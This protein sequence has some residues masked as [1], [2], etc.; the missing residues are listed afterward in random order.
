M[1][2]DSS[3]RFSSPY[4]RTPRT[5]LLSNGNYSLMLTSAGSG[6]SRWRDLA[7]TRW[8]EDPTCDPWGSYIFLRDVFNGHVWSAG[9]Q[10]IG[11]ESEFYEATF[12][13]DR[14]EI[15]RKDGPIRT[16]MEIFVSS[17]D[18]AEVR[19]LSLTNEGSGVREIELTSYAEVVLSPPAADSAHPAFS[20]MFVQTEYV[21]ERGA[22]L[23]TRRP[24]EPGQAQPWMA[25]FISLDAEAVG[26]LQFETDRARFLGRGHD[27]RNAVSVIDARPL[28]NTVG[29]VLDPVLALRRRVRIDPGETVHAAFWTGISASRAQ[30]LSLVDKLGSEA[31]FQRAKTLSSAKTEVQLRDSKLSIED[32]QLFQ[33]IA[34]RVLY[35]DSSQ[36]AA[37]ELLDRNQLGQ[38]DL[39][40]YGVSGDLPIVLCRIEEPAGADVLKQLLRA[41]AYWHSKCLAVDL[42]IMNAAAPASAK[43]VQAAVDAVVQDG[44]K[45]REESHAQGKVVALRA[46]AMPAEHCD[47][48]QTAARVLFTGRAAFGEQCGRPDT[49]AGATRLRR[50]NSGEELRTHAPHLVPALE[51]FNGLGGFDAGAREYVVV[52]DDGQWTPAPW[53]N[54]IANLQFGFL[55]SADG[56]GSTWSL[57]AQQNQITP[58]SN[59]PVSDTPAEAIYVRDEDSGDLW[60]VTPLPIR[61]RSS[62]YVV[63]HGF[64]YSRTEHTSHGIALTLTQFVPLEDSIKIS[65]LKIVNASDGPRQ[66]SVTH[67]VDWMLG[68]QNNRAAP[69]IITAIDPKTGALLARNPWTADFKSRVAFL[70]MTGRQQSC[71]ADRTEFIGRHGSLAEPAALL[72]PQNLSN[73]VGGGLDPCGAMQ[74]KISLSAGETVELT[75][76]LGEE[77]SAGAALSLIAR[78]RNENFDALFKGVTD[79]WD[80]TLGV[81]QV[82]TPDRSMDILINGWLLYQTLSCRVWGRTAFYQSSGAYGYR[83]QLQD[84][85]AL[86]VSSPAIAR[87]HILRA[88]AQQYAAGDVQHWWLPTSG[89]G[90][91]TRVSDDRVWLAFVVAHYLEVTGDLGV[92]DE[93]VPFLSGGPLPPGTNEHFSAPPQ[94][95]AAPLFEHCVRALDSSLSL[96]SHGLPLFGT[97]D[98]NDGMNRVGIAG[99]G[100]SVWLA[101]FLHAALMRFAPI[102]AVRGA[103]GNADVWRKHAFALAQAIERE[104]WDGDWYRRGYYDDGT[105]LG[106]ISSDECRIDSVAQSWAVISGAAERGRALRAMSAVNTQL[107]SRSDGLVKLFTPPFDHSA[108]DPGYIKAYPPGLRENGGQYTHAAMWTTLAFALLGDGDRAG[109]LFSLLNPI[110]HSSTRASIHRYKVEPYVVCADVYSAAPH[111]GRGGWTWYTG[112]AGWMYR[113]AAEGIL[114]IK[115]RGGTLVVDPCIPRAWAGFEFTYKHGSSRYRITVKNPR[116]VNRGVAQATLDGKDLSGA[117]CEIKLTDDGRYHYGEITLG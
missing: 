108:K 24:R 31:A 77:G 88:A 73:R 71:T 112:S 98:W 86:C 35:S 3:R 36:R 52:L 103:A 9:Y 40:K 83:D 105:V 10:P 8:R 111:V 109:E 14:A 113:T 33:E 72:G 84:V 48:L 61:E 57:N 107:V 23:A 116:G 37:P 11:R 63:R 69:F 115:L 85:M 96:G 17:E 99:R 104:A 20:K 110:N 66:L 81:I 12:F 93:P 38:S 4:Q 13:A 29:T 16:V 39:W 114:G 82:K 26:G 51:Y 60:S 74:T 34:A 101:W 102:A 68:N 65:R 46:D 5:L 106:S 47:F 56:A 18:D 21:A 67:Y 55:V 80:R 41:Q 49:P 2:V 58:W 53:I 32:A 100:E 50:E 62:V 97:G 92:L 1:P 78:Y 25:H 44:A 54:V 28:S 70:D 22:L 43:A 59:D 117:A 90:I 95:D 30:A 89:Q 64:G 45:G 42:I 91:K 7:L 75:L 15:R 6:Y 19:H 79:F 87:E 94:G 76:L 27:V